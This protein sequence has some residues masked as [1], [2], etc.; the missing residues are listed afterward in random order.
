MLSASLALK[1]TAYRANLCPARLQAVYCTCPDRQAGRQAGGWTDRR[2]DRE[3]DRRTE[4][5]AGSSS[6][7]A[8][9]WGRCWR[10]I[11]TSNEKNNN[12]VLHTSR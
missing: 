7:A 10:K 6:T 2:A 5:Q 1:L 12:L 9:V 11:L 4:R 3:V 8:A